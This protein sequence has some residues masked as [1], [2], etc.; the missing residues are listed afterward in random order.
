MSVGGSTVVVMT[1]T[2]DGAVSDA[3]DVRLADLDFTVVDVETT[4]WAPDDAGITEIGAVRV[5]DGRVVAEFGSLV[6]PGR[7]VPAPITE[8]TGIDDQMLTGA[9]PVAAVMPGLLAFARGSVLVAHNAPF[10][11]RFLTAACAGMGLGWPGFEV[12]DTVRLARHLMSS[13]QEVPD[14]KLATLAGFFGTPVRPSHRALDDARATADVLGRL[15]ARLAERAAINTL[16][17]LD[18]WLAARDAEA[19]EAAAAGAPGLI[20]RA[21]GR[22]LGRI[23]RVLRR[24]PGRPRGLRGHAR[25]GR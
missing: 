14:R 13:P 12:L 7:P 2:R 20:A 23:G 6:N 8:L 1:E 18:A 11:L 5:H 17:E 19:A 21:L 16:A 22:V 4:G 3:R 15:L 9:P 25:H 24:P 10:D